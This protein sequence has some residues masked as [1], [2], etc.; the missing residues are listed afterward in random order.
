MKDI[1]L[2]PDA[3]DP[4]LPEEFVLRLAR[5]HAPRAERVLEV[6]ES[7]GEAR[8]Y[9][10]DGS[11][12][13]KTQR[14]HRLRTRTSLHKEAFFLGQLRGLREIS[15][16]TVLGYGEEAGVEYSVM[17]RMQGTAVVNEGL[18]GS[19]RRAVLEDLGEML[20]R[21]HGIDQLP[22]AESGLLPQD[23]PESGL[24]ERLRDGFSSALVTLLSHPERWTLPFSPEDVLS[25]ALTVLPDSRR[26]SALHSNPGPTHTFVEDGR[27]AGVIDFGDAFIGHPVHDLR[28]WGDPGDRASVL[29]GYMRAGEVEMEFQA[30]WEAFRLLTDALYIAIAHRTADACR[31]DLSQYFGELTR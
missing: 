6:D 23:D 5:R 25:R 28:R 17:S 10:V 27:L 12:I 1:Y 15:V 26:Q 16:P 2:H 11:L 13:V 19:A 7:G 14:P 18:A 20:R 24:R 29:E 3:P 21:I 30:V 4:V 8:T 9:A 31:E 22:F